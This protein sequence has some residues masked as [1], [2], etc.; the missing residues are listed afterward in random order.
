M[1]LEIAISRVSKST[2]GIKVLGSKSSGG[3]NPVEPADAHIVGHAAGT[4]D[5]PRLG[6]G[7]N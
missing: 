1:R 4:H 6:D 3:F 2:M 7:G 5:Q